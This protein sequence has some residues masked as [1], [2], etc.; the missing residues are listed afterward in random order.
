MSACSGKNKLLKVLCC[1]KFNSV[2]TIWFPKAI[3]KYLALW[4]SKVSNAIITL[5]CIKV[6]TLKLVLLTKLLTS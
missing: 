4:I 6:E 5:S 3:I 2:L 1:E